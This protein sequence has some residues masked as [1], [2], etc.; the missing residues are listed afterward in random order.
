LIT[1]IPGKQKQSK[2]QENKTNK[3]IGKKFNDLM[4]SDEGGFK[5]VDK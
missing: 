1:S 3:I 5:S 4:T 2:N